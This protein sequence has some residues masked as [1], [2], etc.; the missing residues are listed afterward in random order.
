[1]YEN[2]SAT[3]WRTTPPTEITNSD[4]MIKVMGDVNMGLFLEVTSLCYFEVTFTCNVFDSDKGI[5]AA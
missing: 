5:Y 1:M 2:K 3:P 4:V